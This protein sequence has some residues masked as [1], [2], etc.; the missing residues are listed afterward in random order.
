M[1]IKT[2]TLTSLF[3]LSII[4]LSCTEEVFIIEESNC[5]TPQYLNYDD[6]WI[7]DAFIIN[8]ASVTES[9]ELRLNISH[10]GGC[11]DHEYELLQ[12]PNFCGTP[13]VYTTIKLSHNSNG[14]LCEALITK[15]LCFD[16][17]LIYEGYSPNEVTIGLHNSHQ[18]D[19]TWLFE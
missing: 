6:A 18:P 3:T 17:S 9:K 12:E 15:D 7:N 19:S 8:S 2:R 10:S 5:P 16:L 4:L 1:T 13:P 11:Q 14:D